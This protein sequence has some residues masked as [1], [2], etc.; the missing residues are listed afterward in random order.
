MGKREGREIVMTVKE[1][2][3]V[4]RD[5]TDRMSEEEDEDHSEA[6]LVTCGKLILN[7]NTEVVDDEAENL[8]NVRDDL[9]N[10]S[11]IEEKK[12]NLEDA[13]N[14]KVVEDEVI[15][16]VNNSEGD[17]LDKMAKMIELGDVMEDI[18]NVPENEEENDIAKNVDPRY[19]IKHIEKLEGEDFEAILEANFTNENEMGLSEE[20]IKAL[21]IMEGRDDIVIE[22]VRP[23]SVNDEYNSSVMK[24]QEAIETYTKTVFGDNSDK[25]IVADTAKNTTD[26]NLNN[27]VSEA[28]DEEPNS[29]K[30]P[31]EIMDEE[32][33]TAKLSSETIDEEPN[34]TK[35]TGEVIYEEE[36]ANKLPEKSKPEVIVIR[37]RSTTP[38]D[39]KIG[40]LAE[41]IAHDIMSNLKETNNKEDFDAFNT[42]IVEDSLSSKNYEMHC[43]DTPDLIIPMVTS[44][45]KD[46]NLICVYDTNS[47]Q[48]NT[49]KKPV[50]EEECVLEKRI[51]VVEEPFVQERCY[52]TTD[53]TT[54]KKP[55]IEE[56]CTLEER[57]PVVEEPF[58]LERSYITTNDESMN[59]S[60]EATSTYLPEDEPFEDFVIVKSSNIPDLLDF[61]R[62]EEKIEKAEIL[63]RVDA[64]EAPKSVNLVEDIAD[65]ID[66]VK[67]EYK[68][69]SAHC[70]MNGD[71]I[72]ATSSPDNGELSRN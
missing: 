46:P 41:E 5:N 14:V 31:V 55:V 16:V 72:K 40:Q 32:P 65:D 44:N 34:T 9:E 67:I 27:L 28:I 29:F 64:T 23:D 49:E 69:D 10:V 71:A 63:N 17:I 68:S 26:E 11:E 15:S 24:F 53:N 51:P 58:V 1:E 7:T 70:A 4:E 38:K 13:E 47:L 66:S 59:K 6:A 57:I 22:V 52:I 21:E 20:D 33:N 62:K 2:L 19:V 43:E 8:V 39:S 48:E 36:N 12:E 42:E 45:I 25:I 30:L 50:I 18:K 61:V 54:E 37:E 56:E 60:S 35:L 3:T